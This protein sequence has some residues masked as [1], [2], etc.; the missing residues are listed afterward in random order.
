MINTASENISAKRTT[1]NLG[2][3]L[4]KLSLPLFILFMVAVT[5]AIEPKF[6]SLNNL[7]NLARQITPLLIVSAAQSIA[8]IGG[9]LDLSL[10]AVMSLAGVV[11]IKT[12]MAHGIVIGVLA[13]IASGALAGVANGL[14]IGY[15]NTAPFIV[16]LGMLSVAQAFALML[17]GGVPLYSVPD[18][19]VNAIGFANIAGIPV[20]IFIGGAVAA[21]GWF[22]LKK[23]VLGRYIY[24]V[25]SNR[26]A[27]NNSGLDVKKCVLIIY[28][29]AGAAAG[30]CAIVMTSWTGAAQPIAAPELSLQSVAAVILG[31][32]SLAGG[33]GSILQVIYGVVILGTLSNAMNMIGISAYFQT[34]A[35]GVVIIVAVI[36]DRARRKQ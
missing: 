7:A 31:G 4:G 16:T 24:A 14:I 15:L 10:A 5:T 27:A 2:A 29:L 34:L 36:L 12:M 26:N 6:I 22:I 35:V 18:K 8:V 20:A 11:G 25:G 23:S 21:I 33:S 3:T 9:G 17:S 32:V 19:F 13:M 1:K 28:T 30:V